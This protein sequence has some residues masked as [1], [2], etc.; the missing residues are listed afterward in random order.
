M[1]GHWRLSQNPFTYF[2]FCSIFNCNLFTAGGERLGK[3]IRADYSQTY[4][5]PPSLEDW[6][7]DDHP[8]RF[9]RDFVDSLD[10][11][12]LGF[13]LPSADEGRPPYSIDLL[14]KVW[15]YGYLNKIRSSRSL[16]RA[17]REHMS[18][19]WLTGN[20]SPDHNTLW[21]F[22]SGN[23]PALR[24][25]FKQ[26]VAVAFKSDLV[27]LA[28]QAV[29]GSK[30]AACVSPRNGWHKTDLEKLLVEVDRSIES[31]SEAVKL[32]EETR[33][34]SYRLPAD[35]RDAESRRRKIKAALA[36]LT[37]VGRSH[38]HP[39][40]KDA[41]MM[42]GNNFA[43][44]SQAVVDDK[45]GLIVAED[46]VNEETDSHQLMPMVDRVKENLGDTA[47]ETLAD[48]GYYS[49]EQLAEAEVKDVN[50]L[51]SIQDN[52]ERRWSKGELKSSNFSYDEAGNIFICPL[53]QDLRCERTKLSRNKKHKI[54]VY[55][56][57]HRD[58]PVRSVCSRDKRGRA[59]EL[60]EYYKAVQ[61]QRLKQNDPD[62]K[63]L[64]LR[65]MAIVEPVFAQIKEH[66]GFR[67]FT[68]RGLS[69]VKTQWSM[70][71]TAFNLRKLCRHWA[72]GIPLFN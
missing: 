29:D 24:N 26:S 11:S 19:I 13:N 65:R 21:R 22:W 6:I 7:S 38:L 41:R 36:E 35:L 54:K 14:L 16:E 51:V 3:E 53:G 25:V 68:F 50:V 2:K 43:Y 4:L 66:L 60:G 62:K 52:R 12:E 8:A 56:C 1:T 45:H 47:D 49:P 34:G 46:V 59:I 37:D 30:I 17:C 44:N 23:E 39:V 9:I 61:K 32:A 27:S 63:A 40:D 28:V 72:S 15:L 31:M 58:C 5:L 18:L 70:I 55:R 42:K 64:L 20:N 71:C 48:A 33:G 67:R 69:K 10:L 57:H